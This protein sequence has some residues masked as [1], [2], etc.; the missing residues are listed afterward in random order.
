MLYYSSLLFVSVL[1]HAHFV[2]HTQFVILLT[3]ILASSILYHAKYNDTYYGKSYVEVIDKT[4]AHYAAIYTF[5]SNILRPFS[6]LNLIVY[7][8]LLYSWFVYYVVNVNSRDIH[9]KNIMH[10]TI[11]IVSVFGLHCFLLQK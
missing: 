1:L 5:L 8:S 11:H 7:A 3:C 10:M 6:V 9:M 4:I 2:Q